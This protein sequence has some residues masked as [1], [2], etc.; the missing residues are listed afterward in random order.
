MKYIF[1]IIGLMGILAFPAEAKERATVI[2]AE[3]YGYVRDKVYF[4]FLEE[5]GINMEFP[6]KEG[7]VMEFTVDLDDV[8]TL[9]L[10]TFIEIYLQPGD[11][12]HVKV[13]YDGTRY[14]SV[15]FSGTPAAVA[16]CSA[17]N[18]KEMLQR[19]RRYKTNIPAMLVTQTDAKKIHAAT[20]K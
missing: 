5:E 4:N 19:E 6:Y 9:V 18:K 14:K 15:E 7:Q 20:V 3:I 17:I 13:I 1:L 16:I 10:N 11:S 2:S 8:T 12:V